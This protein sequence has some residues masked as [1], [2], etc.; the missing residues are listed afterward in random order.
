M[1]VDTRDKR[2]SVLGIGLAALLVLPA[3][4]TID[5]PD[6]QQLAYSYRG[7]LASVPVVG[8][9]VTFTVGAK[10]RTFT[11]AAK[12]RTFTV[13][14]KSRTFTVPEHGE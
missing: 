12:T 11:V 6:R 10:A 3:P 4:G 7:L 2:A 1:A 13:G 8:V 9:G 5:Q 14:A